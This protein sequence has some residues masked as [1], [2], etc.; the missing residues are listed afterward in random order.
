MKNYIIPIF[1]PHHG[2]THQCVFCNQKKITGLETP[3]TPT[4]VLAIIEE[5]LARINRPRNIEVAFYG[6]SFTALPLA[7][8]RELLLPA[9]RVLEEGRIHAIRLSTRPDCITQAILKQLSDLGVSTIELGAQSLND[10]VLYSTARGHTTQ[11]VIS[12]VKIIKEAGI[13]CGL[14][15]MVGLPNEDWIS[16]IQSS[17]LATKLSPDFIRIYPTLVIADTPLERSYRS[18]KYR[19]LSID[20]A[21]AR[22]A[23]MKTIFERSDIPV[24]RVGLQATEELSDSSVVLA[25]PFHPAFG[26]LVE[27]YLFKIVLIRFLDCIKIDLQPLTIHHHYKDTSKIRGLKNANITYWQTTYNIKLNLIADGKKTGEIII[28]HDNLQYFL[29]I[30]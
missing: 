1:I 12:A 15:L 19:P 13:K 22:C 3:I 27:S 11:D 29:S 5:H 10:C 21:V 9:Y 2:C 4:E 26:E 7:M 23:F 14:Q 17:K 25:G 16:L 8:Q 24:I 6:G 20:E 30:K 28:I 18:G